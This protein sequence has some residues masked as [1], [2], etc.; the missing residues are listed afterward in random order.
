MSFILFAILIGVTGAASLSQETPNLRGVAGEGHVRPFGDQELR[1]AE[2]EAVIAEFLK[3]LPKPSRD[4]SKTSEKLERASGESLLNYYGGNPGLSYNG[5]MLIKVFRPNDETCHGE[6]ESQYFFFSFFFFYFCFLRVV[7]RSRCLDNNYLV[8]PTV[9][10]VEVSVWDAAAKTV[11]QYS[12]WGTLHPMT[13]RDPLLKDRYLRCHPVCK[14]CPSPA[15]L[16]IRSRVLHERI[17]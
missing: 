4:A 16:M 3:N 8:N 7:Q 6:R 13:A 10:E 15:L 14:A 12:E 5:Y 9:R 11:T 17:A 1:L 2:K